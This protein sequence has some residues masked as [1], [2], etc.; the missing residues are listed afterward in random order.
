M[1]I[2]DR[3]IGCN[4]RATRDE[5]NTNITLIKFKFSKNISNKLH[6]LWFIQGDDGNTKN[7]DG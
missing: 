7:G 4:Y 3:G 2:L 6:S 5:F 1:L